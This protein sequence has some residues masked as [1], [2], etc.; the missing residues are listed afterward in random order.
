EHRKDSN[1]VFG[2][3]I[4]VNADPVT[5]PNTLLAKHISQGV[6]Q[7]L[8]LGVSE[9]LVAAHQRDLVRARRRAI[10]KKI[11]NQH[12]AI[13]RASLVSEITISACDLGKCGPMGK[14]NTVRANSSAIGKAPFAHFPSAY[15]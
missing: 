9:P 12:R 6:G 8:Q 5:P 3:I 4:Q 14:L 10:L 2:G 7:I 13:P 11:L 15:A 1:H